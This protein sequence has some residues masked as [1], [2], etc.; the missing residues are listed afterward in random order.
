MTRFG[1]DLTV[2]ITEREGVSRVGG[3]RNCRRQDHLSRAYVDSP[4]TLNRL[5]V[6]VVFIY[7]SY[8]SA[9]KVVA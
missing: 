3:K 9:Y 7:Y 2:V 8:I 1:R 6:V 4:P 5:V